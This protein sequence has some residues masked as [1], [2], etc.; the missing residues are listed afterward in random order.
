M[1]PTKIPSATATNKI[2]MSLFRSVFTLAVFR[3]FPHNTQAIMDI[4][5]EMS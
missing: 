4:A 1:A 2:P 5:S 3:A